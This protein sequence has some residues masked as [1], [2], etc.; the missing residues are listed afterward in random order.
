MV[1]CES[2]SSLRSTRAG[3]SSPVGF[4]PTMG[5]L[6]QAHLALVQKSMLENESTIVSIFVNPTQFD[7]SEDLANYPRDLQRDLRLLEDMNVDCVFTPS[8]DEMYPPGFKTTVH[9]K[10]ITDIL[11]GAH[12]S[13]HF[14]GVATVVTKLFNIVQP[15]HAYFG[16]KDAQQVIVVKQF[17]S[18]LN[19]PVDIRTIETVREHDG[20]A[21]S[22]RNT[23]LSPEGRATAPRIYEALQAAESAWNNGEQDADR[24]RNMVYDILDRQEDIRVEYVSLADQTTLTELD[25]KIERGLLSLAAWIDDVRLIDNVRLEQ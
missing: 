9:V 12:R 3:L 20:L 7:R 17:V 22:S 14:D 24:L 5:F 15:D 18:D 16:Q 6:H 23:L 13:G 25:G 8:A 4:V 21:V 2:I 1:V 19:I 10:E 11:E